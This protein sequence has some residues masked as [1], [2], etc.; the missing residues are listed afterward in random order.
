MR[1]AAFGTYDVT[2]HPRVAVLVQGLRDSGD[3]VIELNEP[4]KL[5]TAGRVAMLRQPWRLPVFG[6][7]LLRCWATLVR[8]SRRLPRPD[9]VLVGYLG[10]TIAVLWGGA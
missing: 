10:W 3:V 9:A 8:R 4:L 2:R 1:W 7:K 5:D 6:G